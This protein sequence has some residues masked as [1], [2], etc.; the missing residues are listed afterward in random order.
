D[1]SLAAADIERT[2][3]EHRRHAH[4][5]DLVGACE[6]A[7]AQLDGD[8]GEAGPSITRGIRQVR[9]LL[10]KV[11][12]HEPRLGE[13]DG[14]LDSAAIQ[15]DEAL[16]ALERIRSDLDLDPATLEAA[17]QRMAR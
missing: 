1:E 2:I 16:L 7:A 10:A 15:L 11:S 9:D 8:E 12:A 5:A 3:A 4:A 17:E 6:A 14:M 13:V